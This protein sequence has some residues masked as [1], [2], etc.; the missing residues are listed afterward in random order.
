MASKEPPDFPDDSDVGYG[1]PPKSTRFKK[2]KSGNPKGRPKGKKTATSI[3]N[4]LLQKK[5]AVRTKDSV[6]KVSLL[7]AMFHQ[8]VTKAAQGDQKA[9]SFILKYLGENGHLTEEQE[10]TGGIIAVPIQTLNNAQYESLFGGDRSAETKERQERFLE[11][12]LKE[13]EEKYGTFIRTKPE[14]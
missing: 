6:M 9:L 14:S 8:Q 5:V 12:E 2:G 13:Y 3:L 1:K 4:E 7:E 11:N 10:P